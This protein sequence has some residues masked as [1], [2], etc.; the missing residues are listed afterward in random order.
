M[1]Y[2]TKLF[3][4]LVSLTLLTNGV[5]LTL[6][7]NEAQEHL[8]QQMDA[9]ALS[10]AAT[11]AVAIDGDALA[12]LQVRQDETTP[13]Y[14]QYETLLRKIRDNNRRSDTYVKYIYTLMGNPHNAKQLLFGVDAE[15]RGAD[16]SHIGDVYDFHSAKPFLLAETAVQPGFVGDQWGNW[17]TAHAPVYNKKGQLVGAVAVDIDGHYVTAR[18]N[19][20][21]RVG[22]LALAFSVLLALL[23][24]WLLAK[25]VT[26]PLKHVCATLVEIGKGD[27]AIKMNIRRHDEF[28]EVGKAINL[29][30][31]GLQ[32]RE[33][34]K[35]SLARYVSNQ[36]AEK[37]IA[38]GQLPEVQG[39]HRKV[40]VLFCDVRNFTGLAENLAPEAVVALLNEAFEQMIEAI[41]NYQGMLDKFLGD[42]FMAIFGAPLD[43]QEQEEHAIK[44]AL[45]MQHALTILAEK[46]QI[47]YGIHFRVGIGINTG[48]AIVGNI[49][50]QQR[51]EY[52][53]IGDTVNLAA[54]LESATKE[55]GAPILVSETTYQGAADKFN[56]KSLGAINVKGRQQA[57]LVYEV[58]AHVNTQ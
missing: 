20:L 23:L 31:I 18:L 47:E 17:L 30:T 54:R 37:I 9:K 6:F 27:L 21:R 24:A 12:R 53:A 5:L 43:D 58:E 15:E 52:T 2:Q 13:L 38:T 34:L 22:F 29:M 25:R 7:Y 55:L 45:A 41:F 40:T 26:R 57:V 35:M 4:L 46:W 32:Q 36:V 56:F 42:G 50:S 39:E 14:H 51:M 16:K 10:I 44:A 19:H 33:N 28:A 8:Q 11:A 1:K 3:I 49:G 48:V